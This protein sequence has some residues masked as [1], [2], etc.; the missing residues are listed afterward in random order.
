MMPAT[1]YPVE[2]AFP[3]LNLNDPALLTDPNW[4]NHLVQV[5]PV[6]GSNYLA[7]AL[8][9]G[10]VV[11]FDNDYSVNTYK[12]FFDI[13]G[14]TSYSEPTENGLHGIAFHPEFATNGYIYVKWNDGPNDLVISR[15]TADAARTTILVNTEVNYFRFPKASLIHNGGSPIFGEDGYLYIPV[16]DGISFTENFVPY[17]TAPDMTKPNGKVL[18]ID[19]NNVPEGAAYGIPQDNPF[20]N[21][22][23]T[24]PEIFAYGLRNP[25]TL[26]YDAMTQLWFIGDVGQATWEEINVLYKGKNYGWHKKEAFNCYYPG[27]SDCIVEN[28]VEPIFAYPHEESLCAQKPCAFGTAVIV[29][30]VYRGDRVPSL[31]GQLIFSDFEKTSTYAMQFNPSN[32]KE[33]V[34]YRLNL[35]G[36]DFPI[37]IAGFGHDHDNNMFILN[38]YQANI[39]RF[40]QETVKPPT[41]IPPVSFPT[42][43]IADVP[44]ST[45]PIANTPETVVPSP[46][47]TTPTTQNTQVS[48]GTRDRFDPR[49]LGLAAAAALFYFA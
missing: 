13:R 29:G 2:P 32:P 4:R 18:R 26:V 22:A 25:W 14:R 5:L 30:G 48:L 38:W 33:N 24:L 21:Q 44:A 6:P 40:K 49:I 3:N 19:V 28:E 45:T 42:E 1:T 46:V 34:V 41:T 11:I 10:I 20:V 8:Q 31:R 7:A 23:G 43:P 39:M 17:N 36:Q 37:N 16:G 15:F 12:I 9:H 35:E 27:E 47:I